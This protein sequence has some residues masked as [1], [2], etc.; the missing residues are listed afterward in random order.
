MLK[1]TG[2]NEAQGS[3]RKL[4]KLGSQVSFADLFPAEF[5]AANSKYRDMNDLIESSGY[6]VV[7][8]EDLEAIP[9]D[10]W[11]QHIAA[12]TDFESWTA[13]QKSAF[14]GLLKRTLEK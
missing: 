14:E 4:E 13:M 1:I 12:N 8:K 2:L 9:D 6:E 5:I 7:S 10:E 3:L 11:E